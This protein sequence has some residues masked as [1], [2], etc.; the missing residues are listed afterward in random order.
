M[1][2]NFESLYYKPQMPALHTNYYE[3]ENKSSQNLFTLIK[4]ILS[5]YPISESNKQISE[6]SIWAKIPI[7][8]NYLKKEFGEK[9][10]AQCINSGILQF[11]D[12]DHIYMP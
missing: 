7:A 8:A 5:F 12:D 11:Y 4:R 2:N 3:Q 10:I 9:I 6:I 1:L